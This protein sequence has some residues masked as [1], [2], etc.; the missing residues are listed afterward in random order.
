MLCILIDCE[1]E[2]K[3]YP[4]EHDL[5]YDEIK[6]IIMDHQAVIK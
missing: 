2:K 6:T 5:I 3:K 1:D 4:N